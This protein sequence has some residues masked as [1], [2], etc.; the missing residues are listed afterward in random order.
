MANRDSNHFKIERAFEN[1]GA[2]VDDHH[3]L[4]HG[5]ADLLVGVTGRGVSGDFYSIDCQVEVKLPLRVFDGKSRRG[6][7]TRSE[8][9]NREKSFHRKWMGRTPVV[10]RTEEE[11]VALVQQLEREA[12]LIADFFHGLTVGG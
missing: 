11:A 12:G 10:I 7:S 2:S 6:R 9:S 8:L 3:S 5:R 1:A 4:G